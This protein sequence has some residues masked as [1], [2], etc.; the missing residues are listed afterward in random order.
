MGK[1]TQKTYGAYHL[2]MVFNGQIVESTHEFFPY[3]EDAIARADL[4]KK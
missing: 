3:R 1:T 2:Y 4:L